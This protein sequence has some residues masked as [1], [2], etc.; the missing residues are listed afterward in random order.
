[1]QPFGIFS[2]GGGPLKMPFVMDRHTLYTIVTLTNN[3]NLAL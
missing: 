1:M 3:W 2:A